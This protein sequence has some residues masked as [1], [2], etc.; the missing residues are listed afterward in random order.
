MRQ[1]KRD[2]SMII[3][4]LLIVLLKNTT[5]INLDN[6]CMSLLKSILTFNMH[7]NI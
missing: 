4:V 7:L 5:V 2:V 1:V 3:H 6:N